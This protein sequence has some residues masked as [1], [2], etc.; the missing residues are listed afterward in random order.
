M[1]DQLRTTAST[2]A[3]SAPG[4]E[5]RHVA[6]N[7]S[8]A[9]LHSVALAPDHAL[10][11][12][13]DSDAVDFGYVREN[14]I[15]TARDGQH[16][17]VAIVETAQGSMKATSG[18]GPGAVEDVLHC[19]AECGTSSASSVPAEQL[20]TAAP[21]NGK[22]VIDQDL[23]FKIADGIV[24]RR[25]VKGW[26]RQTILSSIEGGPSPCGRAFYLMR[27]GVIVVALFPMTQLSDMNGRG[28]WYS[29]RDLFP[30][31]PERTH[32]GTEDLQPFQV[33]DKV[34]AW[35]KDEPRADYGQPDQPGDDTRWS[36]CF[37]L[38]TVKSVTGPH[39][40]PAKFAGRS[41]YQVQ[42]RYREGPPATHYDAGYHDVC[43]IKG[44]PWQMRGDGDYLQLVHRAPPA[45]KPRRA[46][47]VPPPTPT[48]PPPL[49]AQLE[50]F[51]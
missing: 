7:R 48:L 31:L 24:S 20:L 51:A 8:H 38:F 16:E 2:S 45:A 17:M 41:H 5:A 6:L 22:G 33:G 25:L 46:A 30:P 36:R 37:P 3:P 29:I 49:P 10:G 15:H 12:Q 14:V 40:E 18:H 4:R 27:G 9:E 13:L 39:L 42:L 19:T 44:R 28:Y 23:A 1:A 43:S 11:S 32:A 26:S 21:W 35:Y 34:W 47:A 50:L